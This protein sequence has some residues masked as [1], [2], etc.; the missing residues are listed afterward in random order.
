[1]CAVDEL[2]DD[3]PEAHS[4][5][6]CS[7]DLCAQWRL[8]TLRANVSFQN[9]LSNYEGGLLPLDRS[10]FS[11]VMRID[12]QGPLDGIWIIGAPL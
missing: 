8:D 4:L 3:A 2:E 10:S 11:M 12:G 5:E 6:Y 9:S 7:S 1:M